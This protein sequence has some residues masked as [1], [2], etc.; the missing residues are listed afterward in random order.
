[1][2][3]EKLLTSEERTELIKSIGDGIET[4][5]MGYAKVTQLGTLASRILEQHQED[6]STIHYLLN[7]EDFYSNDVKKILKRIDRSTQRRYTESRI[8]RAVNW[9]MTIKMRYSS[10]YGDTSRFVC[11]PPR[12]DYDLPQNQLVTYLLK[13]GHSLIQDYERQY[14]R[15]SKEAIDD[16]EES[17]GSK[18]SRTWLAKVDWIG[19][20]IREDQKSPYL[21][22]VTTP[23]RVT[24]VMLTRSSHSRNRAYH[25]AYDTYCQEYEP[26]KIKNDLETLLDTVRH[27]ALEPLSDDK[28]FEIHI[29]FSVLRILRK[30]DEFE[31]LED[32]RGLIA[33]GRDKVAVYRHIESGCIVSIYYDMSPNSLKPSHYL[34]AARKYR[35]RPS[36]RRPDIVMEIEHNGSMDLF[37]LE[38]KLVRKDH[39]GFLY[40][41]LYKCLGYLKDFQEVFNSCSWPQIGLA[42]YDKDVLQKTP[43]IKGLEEGDIPIMSRDMLS[44]NQYGIVQILQQKRYLSEK[45]SSVP[46][47]V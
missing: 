14:P 46:V 45:S 12:R 13:K 28:L 23:E 29:L 24:P 41:S 1:M 11:S 19:D 30:S 42:I 3:R 16:E 27:Q 33:P 8:P 34:T 39:T 5:L 10:A 38:C 35:N 25:K 7:S 47:M 22:D 15:T 17:Q 26:L 21:D 40:D 9:P 18:R 31:E 36:S 43:P 20:S 2:E 4:Y 6:L 37:C 44:D 32:E